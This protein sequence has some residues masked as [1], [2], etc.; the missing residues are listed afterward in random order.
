MSEL[1]STIDPTA[2]AHP[3]RTGAAGAVLP[4]G[5]RRSAL[6]TACVVLC[7]LLASS[8]PAHAAPAA[9]TITYRVKAGDTLELLA[10]EYYGDRR[11][12]VVLT[13]ANKL[14]RPRPLRPGERLKIPVT[15]DVTTAPGDTLSTLAQTY[16]SDARRAPFLAELNHLEADASLPAGT[17]IVIPFQITHVAAVDERVAAIAATY[18]GDAKNA[19]LLVR[20]NF[21]DRPV[22]GKGEAILVPV[23][24]VRVRESKIPASDDESTARIEKRQQIAARVVTALPTAMAAWRDGNFAAVKRELADIDVDYL[25]VNLAV[26]ISILLGAAYLAVDD[27]DSALARFK[28][29]LERKP[30]HSVSPYWF[31]PRV[32][33][34]WVRA[35]G[36]VDPGP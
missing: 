31:S 34:V 33:E 29:A 21:L 9:D 13:V 16:L 25:D 2:A 18:F 26:D 35:G 12:A 19:D 11:Y 24:Q 22:V 6:A 7:G 3:G 15:R 27:E 28:Q 32:R 14:T 30:R 23:L 36:R 5:A 20:Y 4:S 1:A 10:A 8:P 17:H